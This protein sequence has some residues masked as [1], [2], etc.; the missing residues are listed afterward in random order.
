MTTTP[1]WG[2]INF[3][4]YHQESI[5][6]RY[7]INQDF[8]HQLHHFLFKEDQHEVCIARRRFLEMILIYSDENERIQ[9]EKYVSCNKKVLFQYLNLD[10]N[11]DVFD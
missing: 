2:F 8:N 4:K 11:N 9:F 3:D 1:E 6:N 10:I 7:F 5:S